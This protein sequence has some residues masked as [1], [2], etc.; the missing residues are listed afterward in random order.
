[1][2]DRL[3]TQR[4]RPHLDTKAD[5]ELHMTQLLKGQ[6]HVAPTCDNQFQYRARKDRTRTHVWV[7][8]FP[9]GGPTPIMIAGPCAVED[10]ASFLR[11][12]SACKAAGAHAL[13]G[14]A[15]KPRTSPYSFQGLGEDGL[16]IMALGREHFGLP[17][18]T[19]VLDTRDVGLVARYADVLQIGARNMQ[20]YS[21]LTEVGQT[22]LPI[23]LK[24]GLGATVQ[25]WLQAAEYVLAA[26]NDQVILCERGIQTFETATRYTLDVAAV[27]VALLESHLPVIIDPSHA[28]G[29]RH[30][31]AALG[32]AGIA[33]GANGM[34]VEVHDKPEEAK[35]DGAQALLPEELL[36]LSESMARIALA[37]R[38]TSSDAPTGITFTGRSCI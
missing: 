35:C 28:A 15:F 18:C 24:R 11:I 37:C 26:G 3:E 17:I 1:V 4:Y 10:E 6:Q 7:G 31:V 30:L 36:Y 9:V 2:L 19:E 27:P 23:L 13:R 16:R 29:K 14:G 20:N 32:R 38:D 21:L 25:E 22:G 34:I 5:K 12:A 33:A 8:K